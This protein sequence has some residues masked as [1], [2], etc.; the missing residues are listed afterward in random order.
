MALVVAYHTTNQ[1]G[2][3]FMYSLVAVEAIGVF[4]AWR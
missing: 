2:H 1:V 3:A 4:A